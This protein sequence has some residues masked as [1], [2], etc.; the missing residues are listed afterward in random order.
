MP[1][2]G[3]EMSSNLELSKDSSSESIFKT[4]SASPEIKKP[5]KQT[6]KPKTNQTNLI[7]EKAM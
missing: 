2:N 1:K 7:E 3:L 6:N 4:K 5:T